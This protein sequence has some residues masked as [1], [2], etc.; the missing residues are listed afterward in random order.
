MK[1]V[2]ENKRKRLQS[3]GLTKEF[4]DKAIKAQETKVKN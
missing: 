3:T 4:L 1:L 2:E